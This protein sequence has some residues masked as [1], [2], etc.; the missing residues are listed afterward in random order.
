MR[1]QRGI[2]IFAVLRNIVDGRLI[3]QKGV[4]GIRTVRLGA[5]K[6]IGWE[7]DS[8]ITSSAMCCLL[9]ELGRELGRKGT[10][11][12]GLEHFL[13]QKGKR[14]A[15]GACGTRGKCFWGICV[16]LKC[17]QAD[18]MSHIPWFL[19]I[20]VVFV[21]RYEKKIS[22]FI[23]MRLDVAKWAVEMVAK[24]PLRLIQIAG[25]SVGFLV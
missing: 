18:L 6:G 17:F 11:A 10:S 4:C 3:I 12:A 1:I 20:E 5:N 8:L 22:R 7:G 15:P 2:S 9:F 13:L 24:K 25:Y 21:K 14:V 19:K 16:L 23:W